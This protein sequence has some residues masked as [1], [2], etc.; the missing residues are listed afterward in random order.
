MQNIKRD[1]RKVSLL[2]AAVVSRV[3]PDIM[4]SN[5][6]HQGVIARLQQINEDFEQLIVLLIKAF[7]IFTPELLTLVD[8]GPLHTSRL[9]L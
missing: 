2:A 1:K 7:R 6:Q 8:R 9:H 4:A 5:R 3:F